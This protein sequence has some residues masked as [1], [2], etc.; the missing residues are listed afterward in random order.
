VGDA[1]DVVAERKQ[2]DWKR[3]S[4]RVH[5]MQYQ[6]TIRN[7]KDTPITVDIREP[8]GGDWEILNSNFK[9]TKLDSETIGFEIPVAKNDSATLDYRVRVHW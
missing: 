8:V 4:D 7:H 5:E 3:V 6:I 1:F 2:M 9:A